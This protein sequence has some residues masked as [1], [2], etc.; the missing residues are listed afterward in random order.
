MISPSMEITGAVT[1]LHEPIW[2]VLLSGNSRPLAFR[3]GFLFPYRSSKHSDRNDKPSS[4][5]LTHGNTCM[6]R[7][8]PCLSSATSMLFFLSLHS[9][10]SVSSGAVPSL[11]SLNPFPGAPFTHNHCPWARHCWAGLPPSSLPVC[12]AQATSG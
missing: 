7:Y 2:L 9:L 6:S 11:L 5:H 10:Q 12:S 4:Q 3:V 8:F 1:F